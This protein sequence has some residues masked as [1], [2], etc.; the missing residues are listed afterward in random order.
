MF[1]RVAVAAA[2][3]AGGMLTATGPATATEPA[4]P[5]AVPTIAADDPCGYWRDG[6]WLIG[7]TYWYRHCADTRVVVH[8]DY[9]DGGYEDTCFGPWEK[10][11]L[12]WRTTNAYYAGRLC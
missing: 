12:S 3:A 6:N 11:Q 4:A 9:Y 5:V 7:Y 2:I 1:A 10:R 8:V